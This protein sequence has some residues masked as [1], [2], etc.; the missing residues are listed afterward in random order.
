MI[1]KLPPSDFNT[2]LILVKEYNKVSIDDHIQRLFYL[3]KINYFLNNSEM[4]EALFAW[5]ND[6]EDD[7]WLAQ[8][9]IYSINPN[10]SFWLTGIQFAQAVTDKFNDNKLL[11]SKKT[12]YELMQERDELLKN[13]TFEQARYRYA[14]LSMELIH[15]TKTVSQLKERIEQHSHI[16]LMAHDKIEAI[17]GNLSESSKQKLTSYST[18]ELGNQVNNANFKF[19]MNAFPEPFIF[20]VEDRAELG[21][22][23]YLHSQEVSKYFIDEF[24]VFMMEFTGTNQSI[25]YKPVVLSQFANQGNLADIAQGLKKLSGSK[26]HETIASR[27]TYYFAHLADFCLKLIEANAYHPDIKLTNILVHNQ[28]VRISDRKTLTDKRN[29]KV[30]EVRSSPLY[31]P[32]EYLDY[33]TDD[34][35]GYKPKAVLKTI[36]MPQFMSFQL[37]LALK[38]FLM[39]TQCDELPEDDDIRDLKREAATYFITPTRQI[40]NLSLLAQELT[41]PDPAKRM[42]IEQFS[43]LMC[44]KQLSPDQFYQMV[45][46]TMPSSELGFQEDLDLIQSILKSHWKGMDLLKQANPIFIKVSQDKQADVRVLRM[47]E[48]LALKCFKDFSK[49]YFVHCSQL[50]ESQLFAQDWQKASWFRR[51][52][53]IITFGWYA[54]DQVTKVSDITIACDLDGDEFQAHVHQLEF[55]PVEV[56]KETIGET[57]LLHFKEYVLKH[58]GEIMPEDQESSESTSDSE[59]S[60]NINE[61]V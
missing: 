3:Q 47:T 22:D 43:K 61:T 24:A 45:E 19:E 25:V 1:L 10:A 11:S 13:H 51:I 4:T 56:L 31:A 20:R 38:E 44:H 9:N 58:I 12:Q 15:V 26:I 8:L 50:I 16:L 37:G 55:I 53:H 42:T 5:I 27:C 18:E 29:P 14:K 21:L 41:R 48:T 23:Q 7:G 40:L 30:R 54:I 36:D 32:P 17:K 49:H 33:L 46:Q 6:S 39:L 2:L 57:A 34:H 52:L 60:E 35:K 59:Q 28:M